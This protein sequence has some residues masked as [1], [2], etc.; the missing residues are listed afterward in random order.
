MGAGHSVVALYEIIPP[1]ADQS[2]AIKLR[3]QQQEPTK[4]A[5]QSG[6]LLTVKVRYKPPTEG[7]SK[8]LSQALLDEARSIEAAGLELRWSAAV[9]QYGMLLRDS[10]HKGEA[11][12]DSTAALA[13]G[14]LGQDHSGLRAEMASLIRAAQGLAAPAS[15]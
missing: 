7:E 9:A 3:Y 1:S 5:K 2:G 11:T 13:H 14:A 4:E 15:E 8:L 6:E 12:W 10:E